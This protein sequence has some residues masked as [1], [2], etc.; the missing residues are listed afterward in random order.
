[1]APPGSTVLVYDN[2]ALIGETTVPPSPQVLS[3]F[4][5]PTQGLS[6]GGH[7]FNVV[8]QSADGAA[9]SGASDA[10][11]VLVDPTAFVNA[12]GLHITYD[13]DGIHYALGVADL[14][15]CASVG[16]GE[17]EIR[18]H[19]DTANPSVAARSTLVAPLECAAG[20]PT[21]TLLYNEQRIPMTVAGNVARADFEPGAGGVLGIEVTCGGVTRYFNLG[22]VSIEFEGF[23]YDENGPSANPHLDRIAGAQ[24]SLFR[25]E[26]GGS[27]WSLWD[28]SSTFGQSNPQTTGPFGWYGWY[29]P[30]G[31]YRVEILYEEQRIVSQPVRIVAQPMMLTVGLGQ[32]SVYL[33]ALSRP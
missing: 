20:N 18:I 22:P 25:S 31:L 1:M 33:P 15:G 26:P 23:V 10:V 13:L 29:P 7:V 17:W 12:S 5:F 9:K 6:S 2:F 30:P 14:F 8:A 21:A 4:V 24:A 3:E 16:S 27:G 19:P 32:P 11:E 28:A